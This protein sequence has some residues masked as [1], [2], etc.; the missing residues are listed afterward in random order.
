MKGVCRRCLLA[1]ISIPLLS[2]LASVSAQSLWEKPYEQWTKDDIIKIASDS[3]WAQVVQTSPTTGDR[4]PLAYVPGVTVRLRSALPIRQALVR[5]KQL[6]AKYDKMSEQNRADFDAKMKGLLEC[7]PCA[8]NYIITFGPPVSQRQ[9][10]SGIGSLKNVTLSL[11]EK[12]VY[13]IN[14]LGERRELVHFVAPKHDEDEATFF[15]PR[16]ND[17]G[18]A[19]LTRDNSR[20]IF[21]FEAKNLRTGWGLDSIPERCEF[22]VSKLILN[23]RVEF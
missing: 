10:K 6:E 8:D 1:A 13:L 5:L 3:P 4:I 19:L 16:L 21:V 15:F 17:K 7:P 12:R 14:E 11:L 2:F 22:D 9:M 18:N 20:L 23:G